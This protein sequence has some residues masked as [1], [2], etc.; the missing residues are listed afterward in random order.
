MNRAEAKVGQSVILCCSGYLKR[1]FSKKGIITFFKDYDPFFPG[2]IEELGIESCN[3]RL[4]DGSSVRYFY[5]ALALN[6]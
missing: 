4:K 1:D 6:E 5:W 2:I 3:V